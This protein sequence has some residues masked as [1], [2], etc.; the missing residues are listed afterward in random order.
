MPPKRDTQDVL[1]SFFVMSTA[2]CALMLSWW[3]VHLAQTHNRLSTRPLINIDTAVT[4]P[5]AEALSEDEEGIYLRNKGLGPAR[6]KSMTY[7]LDKV[8]LTPPAG[9]ADADFFGMEKITSDLVAAGVLKGPATDAPEVDEYIK[10]NDQIKLLSVKSANVLK[11]AE[12]VTFLDNR[13]GMMITYCSIYEECWTR[14]YRVPAGLSG[15]AC[16]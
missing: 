13:F 2:L 9:Q 14:C 6:V 1:V 4:R 8:R 7:F 5:G 11:R 10:E 12:W 3:Q 16:K 15:K